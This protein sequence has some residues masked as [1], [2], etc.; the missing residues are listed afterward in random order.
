MKQKTLE[1]PRG[2]FVIRMTNV[3]TAQFPLLNRTVIVPVIPQLIA[4]LAIV[5]R[6]RVSNK[7]LDDFKVEKVPTPCNPSLPSSFRAG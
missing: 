1:N 7:S 4:R 3:S 2:F 6:G 5:F